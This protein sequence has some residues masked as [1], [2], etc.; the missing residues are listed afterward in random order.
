MMSRT[1]ALRPW[2]KKFF[3]IFS[4]D[5]TI[6]TILQFLQFLTILQRNAKALSSS[7]AQ[8]YRRLLFLISFYGFLAVKYIL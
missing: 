8:L 7:G 5:F 4:R 1:Y 6:L 3:P 2:R